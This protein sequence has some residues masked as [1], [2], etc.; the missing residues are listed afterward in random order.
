MSRW[1]F[2]S[3]EP[4]RIIYFLAGLVFLGCGSSEIKTVSSENVSNNKLE[5]EVA[6]STPAVES[7]TPKG[8]AVKQ[9]EKWTDAA[10]VKAHLSYLASDELEGRKTG[11]IGIEKAAK[12]ITNQ[13]KEAGILP[14]FE[15]YKD[16]FLAKTEQAY[17]IV[18]WVEGNDPNLKDEYILIG[19]H[20][21][22]IGSTEEVNG[23]TLANGAN[24]DASGT[25]AVIELAKYFAK[26]K[27][28]GR[29][30]IFALFSAEEM[31]LLG[32]KHL[33]QKLKTQNLNLYS[34]FNIEMIGVPMVNK[35]Y[36]VYL[37]GYE[38][39]NMAEKFNTYSQENIMGFLPQA[40]E[41]NLFKRSDNYSFYT[42]F[43]VPSQTISTF[44]FTNYEYYHHVDDEVENMDMEH[45]A[46]VINKIIP[47][48]KQM[49]LTPEKEVV[50]YD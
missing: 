21:D 40:K 25:T 16:E 32:S 8:L 39:S 50:F 33:A 35:D 46:Y 41:Y 18:G 38:L 6:S 43:G 48:I 31:G 36:L 27:S 20:Y 12:Y 17:N 49:A 37:T 15:D 34:V 45:M 24:D 19:A 47:G 7:I 28:N 10:T 23:D 5:E 14:F 30:I 3:L 44:D 22:H 11:T 4:M 1:V 13:F 9:L 2:L 42:E 26:E 29:S